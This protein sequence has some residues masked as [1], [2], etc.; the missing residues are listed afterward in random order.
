MKAK[1][2]TERLLGLVKKSSSTSP[3]Y[4]HSCLTPTFVA[5]CKF[6]QSLKDCNW[7]KNACLTALMV[8]NLR[9]VLNVPK[10]VVRNTFFELVKYSV[11][12]T[13]VKAESNLKKSIVQINT[14]VLSIHQKS[15][16]RVWRSENFKSSTRTKANF[17]KELLLLPWYFSKNSLENRKGCNRKN[18]FPFLKIIRQ[19]KVEQIYMVLWK[20]WQHVQLKL[21]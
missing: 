11:K 5:F 16:I 14:W 8:L 19:N 6:M 20:H 3:I 2:T 4:I 7:E 1:Q 9:R 21:L 13:G 17:R 15:K 12:S 10:G 18:P